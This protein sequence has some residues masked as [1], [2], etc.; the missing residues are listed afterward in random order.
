MRYSYK[1]ANIAKIVE[2]TKEK[3]D[4]FFCAPFNW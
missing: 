4:Y 2:K 3:R 1:H